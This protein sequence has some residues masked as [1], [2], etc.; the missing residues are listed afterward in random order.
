MGNAIVL[1]MDQ[2][3]LDEDLAQV[4]EYC[5]LGFFSFFVLELVIKLSG[6][7]FRFYFR[8]K[9]NWFDSAVVCV[10]VIDVTLQYTSI[11]KFLP[12][13]NFI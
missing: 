12:F 9:F 1:S 10:S 8:D 11:S 4:L 3:N 5:N 13:K 2:F 7:G 6:F